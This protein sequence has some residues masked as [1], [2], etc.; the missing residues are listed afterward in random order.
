MAKF[1]LEKAIESSY[2]F[3]FRRFLS[4]LGVA[5]FPTVL[6]IALLCLIAA[7][8]WP[9]VQGLQ[10]VVGQSWGANGNFTMQSGDWQRMGH[11]IINASRFVGLIWLAALV[12]RTMIIVGVLET[13][14]DM[15]QGP[16]F[17]Y[18]SLG[19][20]VWRL[21]GAFIIAIIA[22]IVVALLAGGAAGIA[23]WT[24]E[25]YAAG[26]AGLVK[27]IAIAAAVLWMIYFCVRLFYFL[28]TTVVAEGRIALG[29]AWSLGGGNFWRV[30]ALW[31]ATFL[32]IVIVA[33]ILSAAIFGMQEHDMLM[34]VLKSASPAAAMHTVFS[35]YGLFLVALAVYEIAYLTLLLGLG[36]GA[37]ASAY[38]GATA[39]EAA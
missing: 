2:S 1:K 20:P 24:A 38:K 35:Q 19:A 32:P 29:R 28:P 9:E 4:V 25:H 7:V 10:G 33:G 6:F 27:F 8:L 37:M 26:T 16:Q 12:L 17:F 18:F 36:L 13:A 3:A 21:I 30:V 22:A 11:L 14:L 15:R 23:I 31:L 39:P 5:W 34:A